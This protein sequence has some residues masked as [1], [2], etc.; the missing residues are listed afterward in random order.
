[1][2]VPQPAVRRSFGRG[3]RA[4]IS[5]GEN[6]NQF[7]IRLREQNATWLSPVRIWPHSNRTSSLEAIH[8]RLTRR[9]LVHITTDESIDRF[10]H[11]T[12]EPATWR[13]RVE[14]SPPQPARRCRGA[15]P[16]GD[17]GR[18][19]PHDRRTPRH[20]RPQSRRAIR[21]VTAPVPPA[22]PPTKLAPCLRA[23]GAVD[24]GRFPG[25]TAG[26]GP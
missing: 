13:A 5:T 15:L 22:A 12:W 14:Q 2:S 24:I 21:T 17:S 11:G 16:Q 23:E 9:G 25:T 19:I 7:C 6:E 26:T 3:G 20:R 18:A 4:H 10:R 8:H 1:M